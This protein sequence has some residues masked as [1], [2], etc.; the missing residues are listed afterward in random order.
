M[1]THAIPDLDSARIVRI[2]ADGVEI[3]AAFES[4]PAP[5]GLVVFAHCS[6]SARANPRTRLAATALRRTGLATLL[7]DLLMPAEAHDRASGSDIALLAERLQATVRWA[8][9]YPLSANLPLGLFGAGTGAAAALEVA[10]ALGRRI[11]AVVSRGG[12]P[13]L[14][15]ARALLRVAAPT[16]LIVG[17][18]DPDVAA[19]NE[20]AYALLAGEKSLAM[21]QGATHCFSEPGALEEV[22]RLAADWFGRHLGAHHGRSHAA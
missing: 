8:A 16:L 22:A 21:V 3:E 19:L 12:R 2:P 20:D 14:V 10:A 4:P 11:S 13:D 6:G 1:D 15:S 7:P 18:H 9:G 17:A 5:H